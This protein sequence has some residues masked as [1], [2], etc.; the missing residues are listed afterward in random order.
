MPPHPPP[1][2][3]DG[4]ESTPERA[5]RCPRLQD[6]DT[7]LV[8]SEACGWCLPWSHLSRCPAFL[9]RRE[10]GS[11]QEA[12]DGYAS[13]PHAPKVTGSSSGSC[14]CPTVTPTQPP[15]PSPAPSSLLSTQELSFQLLKP[16]PRE[17][18]AMPSAN[19]PQ[20]GKPRGPSWARGARALPT[21]S[22]PPL[23]Y[24]GFL[25]L[26]TTS[27]LAQRGW[28]SFPSPPAPL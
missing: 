25:F 8:P 17:G 11:G 24:P 15:S 20:T 7:C 23:W 28:P 14:R 12:R 22:S 18:R 10:R 6:D 27:S 16:Q 26:I 9:S 3:L 4:A 13:S 21:S 5:E 19:K 2:S 1:R